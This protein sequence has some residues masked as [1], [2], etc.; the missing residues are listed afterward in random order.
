MNVRKST[1]YILLIILIG[2]VKISFAQESGQLG[3]GVI[4]GNP[5]GPTVKY[6]LSEKTSWDLA[7]GF[8]NDI[9]LHGD[10]LFQSW[11]VFPQR[12]E[13]KMGGYLGVGAKVQE[14]KNDDLFGIRV[15]GGLNYWTSKYPIE[16]FI[17]LGPVFELSP[18]TDTDFDAGIGFRYYFNFK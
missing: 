5:T 13:G 4:L 6:W 18:D 7:I 9:S 14:K 10:I 11:D 17:E 1:K 12:K 2:M 8:Q 3:V 16:L 15:V